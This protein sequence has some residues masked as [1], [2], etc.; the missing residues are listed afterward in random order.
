MRAIKALGMVAAIAAVFS[1]STCKNNKGNQ[2][3]TPA[4]KPEG[5]TETQVAP[6]D[7]NLDVVAFANL[8]CKTSDMDKARIFLGKDTNSLF[9]VRKDIENKYAA[10]SAKS[11]DQNTLEFYMWTDRDGEK[12]LGVN[13]TECGERGHNRRSLQFFTYDS[14][15]NLAVPCKRLNEIITNKMLSMRRSFSSFILKIPTSPENENITLQYYD[16]QK[17]YHELVFVWD[18]KTFNVE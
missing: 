11:G 1:L 3:I 13:V 8:F 16:K 17:K 5:N 18:G 7:K 9:T 12:I 4:V 6:Q 10:V 15:L 2:E 14:K